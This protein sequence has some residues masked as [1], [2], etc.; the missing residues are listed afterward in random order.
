[1]LVSSE[2]WVMRK[3]GLRIPREAWLKTRPVRV[4]EDFRVM[5]DGR[6]VILVEEAER[7]VLAKILRILSP[8]PT[9]RYRKIELDKMG[10]M[11][12]LM[13]DG[14]H[15]VEDIVKAVMRETGFSRRNAEL[16][17]Y[18]FLNQLATRGL[19]QF[20]LPSESGKS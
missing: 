5:D 1:M 8:I 18:H 11:V 10:S 15:T 17:V 19:I 12:W 3:R 13:C 20:I 2:W 14:K 6:V 9:P 4:F 16:A 7:S